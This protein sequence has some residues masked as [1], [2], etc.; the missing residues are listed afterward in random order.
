MQYVQILATG[1]DEEYRKPKNM[2]D[3]VV[4][5]LDDE[6]VTHPDRLRL[7]ALF[8]IYKDGLL[9]ADL[10]KLIMHAQLPPQNAD[11][12]RNLELLGVR[13]SRN[14]KDSRPPPLPLFPQ[15]PPPTTAQ[16]E[17]A[18]SRF[19]PAMQQLL[20]SHAS[21]TVDPNVFPYTKPP[22]DTGEAEIGPSATSLRS[23]KP[24]WAKTKSSSSE[25]RQRIIIFMAG[26]ATYSE[27]RVCYDAARQSNK[28]VFLVTSHMLT[29]AFFI[30]QMGDLSTDKR[31]LGI[32][33][34]Q[35][36]PQ[37]PAHLFEKEAPAPVAAAPA[38]APPTAAAR[39]A[40]QAPQPPTQAM[41]NMKVSPSGA[42]GAP[43]PAPTQ[44]SSKLTKDP[45]KKK[46]HF[47][48]SKR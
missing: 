11:F 15:K 16:E 4:R 37:A 35:P 33:A 48:S 21:N 41:G 13:A 20:T 1:L 19:E 7:L 40:M 38:R 14:L 10:Q 29:P 26:G 3:Q 8:L 44:S 2:A 43:A 46:R 9:P 36:K 24:T 12:I 18:L 23:A 5:T 31:K 47:F 42:N 39:A 22:L 28:E 34:E 32:P 17:Y 27:S 25:P 45:E 30:R 6:S